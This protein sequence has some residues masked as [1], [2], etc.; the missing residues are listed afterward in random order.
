MRRAQALLLLATCTCALGAAPPESHPEILVV[1]NGESAISVAIGELYA[2]RRGVPARNVLALSVPLKDPTLTTERHQTIRREQFES[3]V[4]DPIARH[5]ARHDPDGAIEILVTTK[6]V[7]LRIPASDGSRP[8]SHRSWASVDAELALLGSGLDGTPGM[9]AVVNPYFASDEPFA[10]W[11]RRNPE[12]PLR[13]LVA[14]LT[15]YQTPMD[16]ETGVP[17]DVAALIEAAHGDPGA[18][19]YLVDEDPG[20]PVPRGQGNRVMLAPAV[21]VLR[22]QGQRVRHDASAPLVRNADGL[23]GYASWGSNDARSGPAPFYG[24]IDGDVVPGRFA[25]R[26]VAIDLVSTNARSFSLPTRYGQSLVADLLRLGAA[27]AAG[28]VYEPT[29]TGVPRPY[30]LLAN[31]GLGVPAAEAYFRSVPYLGWTNVWVGDPL[32]TT[33]RPAKPPTDRDGDGVPDPQD[34]CLWLPN[35]DQRDTDADGFGNLCD[36]DFDGDGRVTSSEG[37]DPTADL[38]RLARSTRTGL[39]VPHHDLDGDGRIDEQ[40]VGIAQL[41]L[42]LPPG[43]SGR[44]PGPPAAGSSTP[45]ASPMSP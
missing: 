39:Y 24:E 40:D 22:A 28:H 42:H 8:L 41:W 36:A 35:P 26:S 14:R 19:T 27:G 13:Y 25:P 29:L 18:A 12:A 30:L 6:G 33:A 32:M 9:G 45:A 10:R 3:R 11:R 20:Q 4:R 5:L 1:V 44:R 2:R 23:L 37:R 16:P 43:P 38:D 7:P 21:A 31:H 17:R 34:N 15:G